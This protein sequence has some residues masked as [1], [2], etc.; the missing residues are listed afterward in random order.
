MGYDQRFLPT[1]RKMKEIIDHGILGELIYI[2]GT[3]YNS[4]VI[5]PDSKREVDDRQERLG[6][7]GSLGAHMLDLILWYA[8]PIEKLHAQTTSEFSLNQHDFISTICRFKNG[9]HGIVDFS[10]SFH[11]YDNKPEFSLIISASQ[12]TAVVDR[13]HICFFCQQDKAEFKAGEYEIFATELQPPAEFML[14]QRGI[15][16]EMDAIADVVLNNNNSYPSWQIGYDVDEFIEAIH[17][18]A[19]TGLS[20]NFPIME[21]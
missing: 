6:F 18:S 14:T 5:Q 2:R 1:F 21:K 13:D 8:G 12:G 19:E 3:V 15:S 17:K 7:Y 4:E 16:W 10:W 11:G 9:I 20:V